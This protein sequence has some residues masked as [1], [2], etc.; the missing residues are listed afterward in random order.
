[1]LD[2]VVVGSLALIVV[3]AW[4]LG[5]ALITDWF[6]VSILAVSL[7]AILRFKIN[8]CL[9]DSGCWDRLVDCKRLRKLLSAQTE[10]GVG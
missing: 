10:A 6:T 4:Q 1:M 5:K 2:G 9:V 3:V 8:F 7:L